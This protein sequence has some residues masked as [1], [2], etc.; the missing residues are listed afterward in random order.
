MVFRYSSVVPAPRDEVFEWHARPG[1]FTRL[2]PP[3]QPVRLAAEADS[4]RD[5]VA[6]LSFPGGVRWEA[7]HLPE[8]YD[9][10]RRFADRL[11]NPPLSTVLSWTH[12][13]DFVEEADGTRVVDKVATSVP[14]ALL[15][16]MFAYRHAQLADD[17]AAGARARAWSDRP[18]TVAVT[19]AG[20]LVGRNLCALLTTGG[21]RVIRLV[22]RA[23][24]HPDERRWDPR[25]PAAD[26]LEGVDAL[27][28]LAGEPI[29]GRFTEEHKA[30]LWDSRVEPTRA[31]AALVARGGGPRVF[32]T[33]SGI[34]YYGPDRGEEVLTEDSPRGEGFLAD[35]VAEWEAATGPAAEAGVRCVQVRT[36]IVQTPAGG[37]LG[38]QYPLFAAGLGGR[39][40]D[41]RQWLSWIG[42]DDLSDVYVRAILDEDLAG[43]INGVTPYP[44][45]GAEHARLLAKTLRRP[46]LFPV[47]GW[48]P[49]VL[50]GKE[51]A[52]EMALANQRVAP[53][54]LA[55]A[56]HRFRYPHLEEALAH[57]FGRT[58]PV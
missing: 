49:A 23:P 34:G 46:S 38:L 11:V 58:E 9:P 5:G 12:A 19:G 14:D 24:S 2:A 57:L 4:L 53:G 50:L 15:R 3:W 55:R 35:L 51:G 20:G 32:V 39:L 42:A 25:E 47:P 44:V 54:R 33:A 1:A 31:L 17:L 48:A 43:P 8:R 6:V 18:L 52:D 16:P 41:G 56:G 10:P 40:G 7:A 21:H 28:H 29:F 13:H 26:L 45:R 27:V 36:G 37:V 30:E 22:R